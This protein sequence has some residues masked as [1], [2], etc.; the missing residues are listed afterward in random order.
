MRIDKFLWCVRLCNS[1]SVASDE[2]AAG[3]VR[4]GDRVVKAAQEVK[5]GDRF[6]LRRP[7][8]WHEYEVV[9]LPPSRV[10]AKLVDNFITERT[11]WAELE[12]AEIARKVQVASREP[13]AGRPTKRDRRSIERFT[14]G[15]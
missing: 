11:E 14:D 3:H 1:R 7:P 13:G 2:C 8:I 6:A 10:G 4:L 9:T 5:P 15:G 12:R